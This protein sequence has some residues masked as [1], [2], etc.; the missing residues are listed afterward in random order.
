MRTRRFLLSLIC[1]LGVAAAPPART[2]YAPPKAL[3]GELTLVGSDSMEP[4]VILWFDAFQKFHP[5]AHLKAISKGSATAP[6]ALA[7]GRCAVGPMSRA[8]EAEEEAKVEA[9]LGAKPMR[10]LVAYDALAIWVNRANPI[11]RLTLEQLD[12]IFSATKKRG[13]EL[14]MDTWGDLGLRGAW[15]KR[16][17]QP[18]G[19]DPL[20]GTRA[21]FKEKVLQKGE[22]SP[23]CKVGGDQWAVVEAPGKNAAGISYGPLNYAEPIVRQVPLSPGCGKPGVLPT[24]ENIAKGSYP[25]T[26][27]LSLYLAQGPKAP[28]PE[29]AKEFLRF[30]LSKEGQDLVTAYGAVP[31][32]QELAE[33]Q[34]QGL[35][36]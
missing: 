18:F 27:A 17:I 31:V 24:R 34:L 26:R 29:L 28:S 14:P 20:S 35:H 5:Q 21:F 4:L 23:R 25:L 12:A 36:P 22:F 9:A 30:V 13:W 10:L 6:P 3:E 32:A 11:Q 7:E 1:T 2:S 33:S 8:M 15:R 16:G 19:R